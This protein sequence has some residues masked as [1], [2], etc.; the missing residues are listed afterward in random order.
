MRRFEFSD[1]KSNK[2]WEI[3]TE[4]ASVITRWGRIGTNGQTKSKEFA[5]TEVAQSE[6]SK[7]IASKVRKG[8]AEVGVADDAVLAPPTA[9]PADR[10]A[11][12]GES[13]APSEPETAASDATPKAEAPPRSDAAPLPDEDTFVIPPSWKSRTHPRRG[14]TF[15]PDGNDN[16]RELLAKL[17]KQC[18][19]STPPVELPETWAADQWDEKKLAKLAGT[20]AVRPG[21]WGDAPAFETLVR[22]VVASAGV[23]PAL[24]LVT[25]QQRFLSQLYSTAPGLRTMRIA[26]IHCDD[27][28]R[29]RA[30]ELLEKIRGN[31][32]ATLLNCAYLVPEETSWLNDAIKGVNAYYRQLLLTC[33]ADVAGVAAIGAWPGDS[34]GV[35]ETLA[36]EFGHEAVAVIAPW[37]QQA[38][39][40]AQSTLASVLAHIPH[41]DAV[42][43]LFQLIAYKPVLRTLPDLV[44][45]YPR[46]C[47]RL[48]SGNKAV[49]THLKG[50]IAQNPVATRAV[51]SEVDEGRRQQ[52]EAL[53]QQQQ[54]Q[55]A[56]ASLDSLPRLF[57]EPPW[58]RKKKRTK[59]ITLDITPELPAPSAS[60]TPREEAIADSVLREA[61]QV[62]INEELLA[63]LSTGRWWPREVGLIAL[64][65][66]GDAS[67][68]EALS[69]L[70]AESWWVD[71]AAGR[72][73]YGLMKARPERAGELLAIARS[74]GSSYSA[75]PQLVLFLAPLASPETAALFL[76]GLAKK[77]HRPVAIDWLERHPEYAARAWIPVAVGKA[78]KARSLAEAGLRQLA[79]RGQEETVRR[80][81]NEY[82][83][84]A[85]TA[86]DAVFAVD[87][88]ETLPRSVPG[89]ITF[90]NP[91]ALPRPRLRDRNEVLP[92]PAIDTLAKMFAVSTLD[93]AYEGV[94]IT[95][96]L[97]TPE[98]L[99]AFAWGMFE[100]W[101]SVGS[102]SKESWALTALGLVG[103]DEIAGKLTPMIRAWPGESQ[104]QRAVAGLDVL[105]AIGTDVALMHLNGIAQKVKFKGIKQNAQERIEKLAET[106]GL[107]R[108]QLAD[109]LVPDLDLEP[110]GTMVLDYGPR[111]F[112]V[113]FDEALK[114][115]VKDESGKRRKSLP[116]PG[117]KDDA[118]LAVPAEAR[119][120]LL[121]KNV[122]SLASIQIAR[123]HHAMAVGRRWTAADFDA[124]LVKHPLLIHLVR[125]LIWGVYEDD[126][127]VDS[128]R[129][130]EDSTLADHQDDELELAP[131]ATVGVAHA[132]DLRAHEASAWGELLTD[133]E[134][135]QPFPQLGR[136]VHHLTDDEKGAGHLDRHKG[137]VVPATR[138]LGLMSRGWERGEAQDGGAVL[139]LS[140]PL[141]GGLHEVRLW[142]G[143]VGLWIGMGAEQDQDPT[144][145]GV[146]IVKR[147]SWD[148]QSEAEGAMPFG[149]LPP[150][151]ASEVLDTIETLV[152]E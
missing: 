50:W 106:L 64:L 74:A 94:E 99:A 80:I 123:L 111:K 136:P 54:Q 68:A 52:L 124:F 102:P 57:A 32:E 39:S 96:E 121:K 76:E 139:W 91:P 38:Q 21:Q 22:L 7:Q 134:L 137:T 29:R 14:G 103:N 69:K 108:E 77:T 49:Q 13:S 150:S 125:R 37:L 81:A 33:P 141:P 148:W 115:F 42:D 58:T 4:G 44:T 65:L 82:G 28:E 118:A 127:L 98:S 31:S 128:F 70:V 73:A 110:D 75:S 143:D 71:E 8:Y 109:R 131:E 66:R 105:L 86:V 132:I 122:R 146:T 6:A 112:T 9:P 19:G 116:K 151:L 104:H 40:E 87:P 48:A 59:S 145:D 79:K 11:A 41:D 61:G 89:T 72:L 95:K 83:P 27:N 135:L 24:R 36:V 17:K 2:F 140:L 90:L 88:L 92:L 113:G 20:N 85:T 149:D 142:V 101:M 12:A 114:P 55:S 16:V 152:T 26:L 46:R 138:F 34:E 97:L 63:T 107:T 133:Y 35:A 5:S 126:R 84:G 93:D 43:A 78:R 67:H 53:M 56:E 147:H 47:I 3:D 51:L 1:S 60:L 62:E 100:Q 30:L 129:V 45:R 10:P 15:V 144:F 130:T 23:L 120:K 119:F 117:A 25:S 18:A